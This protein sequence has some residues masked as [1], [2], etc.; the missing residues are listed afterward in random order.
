M[1]SKKFGVD[2]SVWQKRIDFEK[3]KAE[4]VEFVIARAM[5]GNAKD[6]EF[7]NNYYKAQMSKMPFGCYQWGRASN[8]AQA[9]EE[10]QILYENCLKG[11]KF[12]YPIYYDVEDSILMNLGVQELTEVIKA[13]A[14]YLEDRGYFVG[15]YMNQSAFNNEV[16]GEELQKLYSQWRAYWTT[17]NNKPN[18]DMW[19]FGGETNLIKSNMLAGYICDQDYAYIDFESIIRQKGLNGFGAELSR[20]V[21]KSNDEIA[22]EVRE[23]KWGNG[24]ARRQALLIEGYNYFAIQQIVTRLVNENKEQY[25]TIQKGDTLSSIAQKFN[26]TVSQLSNWNNIKNINLIIAGKTIR[27][28]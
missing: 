9:R 2:I 19:Q 11:K 10:A 27:V 5:Y 28:K 14:E 3:L 13:W 24:E 6:T 15:V 16:N 21:M 4:G 26:T 18:C 12:E 20:K 25:Y 23:G 8:P 1:M 22:Q 7:E 17:E